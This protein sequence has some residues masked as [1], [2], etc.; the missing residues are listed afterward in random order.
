MV[1]FLA[2]R[3]LSARSERYSAVA[4]AGYYLYLASRE[5]RVEIRRRAE[6]PIRQERMFQISLR[7]FNN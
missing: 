2:C 1:A 4:A 7:S 6:D 5:L 3:R